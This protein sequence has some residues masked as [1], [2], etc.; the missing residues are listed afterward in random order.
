MEFKIARQ[1]RKQAIVSEFAGFL[2]DY[3]D[4]PR[5]VPPKTSVKSSFENTKIFVFDFDKTLTPSHIF[6]LVHLS[7]SGFR[8]E[9]LAEHPFADPL[10]NDSVGD[11]FKFLREQGKTIY[12][13]SRNYA[14]IICEYIRA[15]FDAEFPFE[16]IYSD[17]RTF[18]SGPFSR[19]K[20]KSRVFQDN[21]HR[22]HELIY[23][24]DNFS[25]IEEFMSRFN[26]FQYHHKDYSEPLSVAKIQEIFS[27]TIT[28]DSRELVNVGLSPAQ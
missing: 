15:N 11:L 27:G 20:G 25:E 19:G 8:F 24:D 13:A 9:A 2:R 14:D 18:S 28:A 5:N 21:A 1:N 4:T 10:F 7:K 23:I 26:G 22:L 12:I 3:A 17:R 16:N 6:E